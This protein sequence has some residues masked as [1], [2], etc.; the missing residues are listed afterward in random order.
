MG[1]NISIGIGVSAKP[2]A[3]AAGKEAAL[4]SLKGL[5]KTPTI[6]YIFFAGDYDPYALSKGLKDALPRSE[7]VGGSAD[8]VFHNE[9]ILSK[10]VVAVSLYSEYLHVGVAS[11]ENA[12]KAPRKLAK[13]A[14][15]DALG[16]VPID[17][18]VD[19][20][21]MFTRMKESSVRWMVK[22]PSF[23]ITL[24]TRGIRLP[25]MGDEKEIIRG[26]SEVTGLQ[27][28]I[29]GGSFGTDGMNVLL[30][31]P[32]DIWMLHSGKVMKDGLIVLF[33]T[34]SLLYSQSMQNGCAPTKKTGFVSKVSNGGFVVEEISNQNVV[35][36]YANQLGVKRDAFLK[37]VRILTQLNPLGVPDLFG[38]FIIRGG[39][40]PMGK[41][42]AYVAPLSEGWP[43]Y[44]M[45]GDAKHL[46]TAS[47]RIKDD[48]ANYMQTADKPALALTTLCVTRKIVLQKDT[49]KEI[50]KLRKNLGTKDVAGFVC[51]GETGSRP[52]QQ[53]MF[54]HVTLN[55]FN[56]YDKLMTKMD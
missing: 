18:Y 22:L 42:L 12:S 35:D 11:V 24:L 50:A 26:I 45:E 4:A 20:Y 52:G 49:G 5:P 2:D 55:V 32:Y 6:T 29:W 47:D 14:I 30:G 27:V 46:L 56:L 53:A 10:G 51:F 39:G 44:V 7:F 23:F 37:D 17:K 54:E 34:T 33:N 1:K 16:K 3:Y 36:W 28:P 15:M 41:G 9:K 19:P 31:K 48:I 21:L 38:G 13:K 40:I 43:V 8:S 25:V